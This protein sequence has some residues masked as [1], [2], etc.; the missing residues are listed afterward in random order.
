MS[1]TSTANGLEMVKDL[2]ERAA[3][4]LPAE[5][6]E[7]AGGWWLRHAPGCSWWVG[8][9]LPHGHAESAG[10]ARR[11]AEAEEFYA[12][13]GL[14]PRFQ[15]SPGACPTELDAVLAGRGY[16]RQSPMSLRTAPTAQVLRRARAAAGTLRVRLDGHPTRAWFEAWHAVHG[17]GDP[18]S[19]RDLL[20]RVERPS[21][22]ACALLGDDV[23]AVGRAVA[24]TGWAGVFGMATLPEARG[25]GAARQVL[26]ALADWAGAHGADRMY[27]QVERDNAPA[28]RLYDRTGFSEL[29]GYHYRAAE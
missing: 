11:V 4:A 24:D 21:A 28:L 16:L 2:Q 9:V 5:R 29:C 17:H 1:A 3:R 19:E 18:R 12:A 22:Y 25:R 23:L 10:L 8:T 20:D 7:D 13:R 15:I 6:V 26:A 14:V 27:L